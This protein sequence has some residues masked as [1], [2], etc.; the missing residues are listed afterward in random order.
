MVVPPPSKTEALQNSRFR[1]HD[2]SSGTRARAGSVITRQVPRVLQVVLLGRRPQGGR[3]APGIGR[4]GGGAVSG[5]HRLRGLQVQ[6]ALKSER[7]E[8]GS[9]QHKLGSTWDVKTTSQTQRQSVRRWEPTLAC[10]ASRRSVSS[11]FSG[12]SW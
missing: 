10:I 1:G 5:A 11:Y 2:F 9:G 12:Q 6:N 3:V 8:E 7:G 4:L